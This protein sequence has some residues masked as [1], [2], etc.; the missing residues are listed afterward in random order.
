MTSTP[1]AP[2]QCPGL[3]ITSAGIHFTDSLG[4]L[5]DLE[6]DKQMTPGE[7]ALKLGRSSEWV[8]RQI[9]SRELYP[10][11]YYNPR[12]V[13]VFACA[14]GDFICRKLKQDGVAP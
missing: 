11:L 4:R 13:T 2:R 9:R 10:V 7:V 6:H 1:T 3:T 8:L 14:V 12:N 5:H